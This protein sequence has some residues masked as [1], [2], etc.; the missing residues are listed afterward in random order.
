MYPENYH[1]DIVQ[2]TPEW[3][4][5]KRGKVSA[6]RVKD[7]MA[8][9][10]GVTRNNYLSRIVCEILTGTTEDG[11]SNSNMERGLELEPIARQTYE[12]FSGNQVD[13]C[14]FID[15]PF[16]PR[17]GCSPDGLVG[18]DGMIEIKTVIPSTHLGYIEEGEA[19]SVYLKQMQ[20]QMACSGRQWVDFVSYCPE[21]PVHLQLFVKRVIRDESEIKEIQAE[22]IAFNNQVDAKLKMLEEYSL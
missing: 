8:G 20:S 12:F 16:I 15:H 14:G 17:F 10:K 13:Q 4:D 1:M 11:F 3:H 19:P 18:D 2:N 22:V 9:G 7:V 5:I 6:S 21:M